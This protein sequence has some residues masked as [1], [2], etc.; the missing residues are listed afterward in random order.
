[1]KTARLF[2]LLLI[3]FP[4]FLSAQELSV[5]GLEDTVEILTDRWGVAHIYANNEHDLFFAQGYSAAK[6]RT[7]QFELWRRRS[8]RSGCR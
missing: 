2:V 6:D 8:A 4:A 7:F 5:P 1:M 3:S